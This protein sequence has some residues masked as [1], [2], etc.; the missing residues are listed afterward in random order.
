MKKR[1][2]IP[3]QLLALMVGLGPVAAFAALEPTPHGAQS[4][5]SLNYMTNGP[6]NPPDAPP[7]PPV[8]RTATAHGGFTASV[9]S[10][11]VSSSFG[12]SSL[13]VDVRPESL[14]AAYG[15]PVIDPSSSL[16]GSDAATRW[17]DTWTVLGGSGAGV[18][19]VTLRYSADFSG[20]TFLTYVFSQQTSD[21][22]TQ[23]FRI[24]TG[25]N[26]PGNPADV[27]TGQPA[28]NAVYSFDLPFVYGQPFQVVSMLSGAQ[29]NGFMGPTFENM[30]VDI[31]GI[32]LASGARLEA[33]SGDASVYHV[34]AVPEP[35][36]WALFLPGLVG[37]LAIARRRVAYSAATV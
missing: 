21:D 29:G 25:L 6:Q 9:P 17:W 2:P 13:S 7:S 30:S 36:A 33:A 14:Q 24:E 37:I 34:S 3:R 31:A 10:G 16:P 1:C 22:T 4:D 8:Q 28:T 19:H 32:T 23:R 5:V 18:A 12:H 20:D 35:A 27:A 11:S 15:E 26:G